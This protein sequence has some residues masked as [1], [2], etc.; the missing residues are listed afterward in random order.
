MAEFFKVR[1]AKIGTD[2]ILE[3]YSISGFGVDGCIQ[4]CKT[5]SEAFL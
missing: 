2:T 4:G 5:G 1:I 3:Y